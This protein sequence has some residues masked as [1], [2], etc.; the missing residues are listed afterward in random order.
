MKERLNEQNYKHV[1]SL[2]CFSTY[3]LVV[4][5]SVLI[6]DEIL[7]PFK[8]RTKLNLEKCCN[9]SILGSAGW[10]VG[11]FFCS[12]ALISHSHHKH[13]RS[14][15]GFLLKKTSSQIWTHHALMDV[16]CKWLRP[17]GNVRRG[18]LTSN[19]GIHMGIRCEIGTGNY[20]FPLQQK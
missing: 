8:Q 5:E 7:N 1:L 16:L 17:S 3:S 12:S 20:A 4:C 15:S 6:G 19:L 18:M 2:L 9:N 13:V 11:L 14:L 10:S